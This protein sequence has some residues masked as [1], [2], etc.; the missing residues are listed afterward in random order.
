[1]PSMAWR[2]AGAT[3]FGRMETHAQ[4]CRE[5]LPTDAVLTRAETRIACGYVD[6]MIGKEIAATCG[7][8]YNTVVRHTQNIYEKTGIRRSTNALVAWFLSENCGLDLSEFRRR[9]GAVVLLVIVSVQTVC[10]DFD[11]SPVRR[12]PSRRIEARKGAGR[13]GRREDEKTLDLFTF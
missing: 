6:G 7:V 2:A 12:F 1:M 9:L 5:Q 8:S 13:K 3:D 10:V 4:T 11:N